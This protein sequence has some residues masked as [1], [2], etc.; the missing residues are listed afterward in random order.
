MIMKYSIFILIAFLLFGSSEL[1][2]KEKEK[3]IKGEVCNLK[4]HKRD[5]ITIK[6]DTL[7]VSTRALLPDHFV[8]QHAGNIGFIAFG[9][10]YDLGKVYHATLLYGFLNETFGDSKVAVNTLSLKNSFHLTK[11]LTMLNFRPTAGIAINWG[12]TKNTF[13][14]LPEQYPNRYYFQNKIHLAP[15]VGGEFTRFI[16]NSCYFKSISA[17][18]EFSSLDAYIL[19][20]IRRDYIKLPDVLTLSVGLK[21]TMN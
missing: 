14:K 7:I 15:L 19:E 16:K 9:L 8:V 21:V 2:A 10:G 12:Y 18:Y 20:W 17:Y 1:M 3:C 11:P 6:D 5:T 13:H 4:W